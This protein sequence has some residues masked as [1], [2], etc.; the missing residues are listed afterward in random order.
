MGRNGIAFLVGLCSPVAAETREFGQSRSGIDAAKISADIRSM[1]TN[2]LS[3]KAIQYG[4]EG[5]SVQRFT[6]ASW[7]QC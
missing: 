7:T 5:P 3:D 1:R 4:P 6:V 2:G